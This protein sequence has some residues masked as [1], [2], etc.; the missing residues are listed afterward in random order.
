MHL[1]I[2]LPP[3]SVGIDFTGCVGKILAGIFSEEE[4]MLKYGASYNSGT[5]VDTVSTTG[6]WAYVGVGFNRLKRVVGL[7]DEDDEEP[8]LDAF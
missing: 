1:S 5:G 7:L 8:P 6:S 3:G 2:T 4:F